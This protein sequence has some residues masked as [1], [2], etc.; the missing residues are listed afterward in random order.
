MVFTFA[1]PILLLLLF[2]SI[3]D[4]TVE[5]T[6]ISYKQVLSPASSPPAS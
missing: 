5:G 3:F 6:D 1:F 2:G 4:G